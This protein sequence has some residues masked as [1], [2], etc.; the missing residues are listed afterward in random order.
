MPTDERANDLVHHQT[1]L[2]TSDL[3]S[4]TETL[5][6][7][8]VSFVSTGTICGGQ[9]TSKSRHSVLIRDP[10]GHVMELVGN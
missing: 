9:P 8:R 6:T 5:C 4:V 10:D 3:H 2:V 7:T 1:V